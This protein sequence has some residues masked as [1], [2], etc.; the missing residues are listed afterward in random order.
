MIMMMSRA[1]VSACDIGSSSFLI[2][3]LV[4]FFTDLLYD[5]DYCIVVEYVVIS[6]A[7]NAIKVEIKP[8]INGTCNIYIIGGT[9]LI[10]Q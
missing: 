5:V 7:H 2:L 8:G 4:F 9:S 1:R 3:L 10:Q 6:S